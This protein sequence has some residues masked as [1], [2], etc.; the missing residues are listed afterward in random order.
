LSPRKI[1]TIIQAWQKFARRRSSLTVPGETAGD[2]QASTSAGTLASVK[3]KGSSFHE[4]ENNSG[5][6]EAHQLLDL[7]LEKSTGFENQKVVMSPKRQ[8]NFRRKSLGERK[9]TK[10][11][12]V[13]PC[14]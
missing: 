1:D 13:S 7:V 8:V 6:A 5:M 2:D 9:E 14:F 4:D 11:H 3:T 10:H 12:Q